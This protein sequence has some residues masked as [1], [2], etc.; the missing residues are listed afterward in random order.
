[1]QCLHYDSES[2][3]PVKPHKVLPVNFF[4]PITQWAIDVQPERLSCQH[5]HWACRALVCVWDRK[6][7]E[8]GGGFIP[9]CRV[10]RPLDS[11]PNSSVAREQTSVLQPVFRSSG[12][13]LPGPWENKG[14]RLHLFSVAVPRGIKGEDISSRPAW[15]GLT[16]LRGP[17]S[18]H[19]LRALFTHPTDMACGTVLA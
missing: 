6:K 2:L 10:D 9:L 12:R 19:S 8:I 13:S 7:W 1:M 14:V 3:L 11:S 15:L 16:H 4:Q 5:C 17:F 18:P